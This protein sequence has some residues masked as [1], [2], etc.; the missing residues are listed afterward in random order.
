MSSDLILAQLLDI[1]YCLITGKENKDYFFIIDNY[2]DVGG[3]DFKIYKKWVK[4]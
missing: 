4:Q 1:V 3:V 2:A